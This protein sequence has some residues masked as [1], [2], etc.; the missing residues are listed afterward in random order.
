MNWGESHVA[1]KIVLLVIINSSFRDFK[2]P[3]LMSASTMFLNEELDLI[4]KR[5]VPVRKKY[6]TSEIDCHSIRALDI[7]NRGKAHR[8][9]CES[10]LAKPKLKLK[11]P[12]QLTDTQKQLDAYP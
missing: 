10:Q 4:V 8:F 9:T 3:I 12:D 1:I 7:C 2:I 6:L 11:N 5:A